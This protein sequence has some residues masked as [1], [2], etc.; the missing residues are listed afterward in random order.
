MAHAC[1]LV[2]VLIPAVPLLAAQINYDNLLFP[3]VAL[4][5]LLA[6]RFDEHLVHQRRIDLQ[7][8]LQ[9][10]VL[11]LLTSLVKYAFLPVLVAISG[12]VLVRIW[13]RRRSLSGAWLG[14]AAAWRRLNR[15]ARVGLLAAL[16]LASGLF[17]QR[18]GVNLVRYHAPVP[19][20][21]QVLT[22]K[23]C[24][25]YGPWIRD[26]NYKL[27]KLDVDAEKSPLTFTADWFYGMWLRLFF[28]VSGPDTQFQ[29]RGPLLIPGIGAIIFAVG[30]IVVT[31]AALP[32]L[33][34]RYNTS[35]LWLCLAV[36]VSY[37]AALWLDNYRAY[38]QVGQ[39]VAINGRYLL[40]IL[41][42]VFLV[43]AL[44]LNELTKR[45]PDL[46]L[47]VVAVSVICL[48]WG[49]GALTFILRSN[50]DWYWPNA[51]VHSANHAVQRTL[52]PLTPGYDQPTQFLH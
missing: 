22:V 33:W 15:R 50:N 9:L 36:T 29:T 14:L 32:K 4:T 31:L 41:L 20:C 28:A 24:S 34:G 40:P 8:L 10:V 43:V 26:Y 52:G 2:F 13:Q 45:R 35:R 49:G 25:E 23:Q 17:M 21:G 19:D 39:P 44:A 11:C 47:I 51:A 48:A 46:K 12:F 30:G 27:N 37:V 6:L 18:Y 16:L 3:L 5:L 7:T 38:L 1:L 42:P